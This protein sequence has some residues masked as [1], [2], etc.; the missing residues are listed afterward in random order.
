MN[1]PTVQQPK[2]TEVQPVADESPSV[3]SGA[4][5]RQAILL[6]G[7]GGEGGHGLIHARSESSD[8]PFVSFDLRPLD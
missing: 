1:T 8:T 6:T 2:P 5:R 3:G 4:P 7:A